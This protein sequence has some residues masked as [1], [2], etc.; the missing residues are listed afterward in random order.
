MKIILI[1]LLV[2]CLSSF[3]ACTHDHQKSF[4]IWDFNKT[5]QPYLIKVVSNGI[6]GYDTA[7]RY[8]EKHATDNELKALSQSEHPVLRALAFREMLER[9]TFN[10][11]DLMMNNLDDTA[12]VIVD[13]GE[14][15]YQFMRVSDDILQNG[16]W[17]DTIMKNKTVDAVITKHNYLKSAYM[18]VSNIKTDNK[19]YPYIKDMATR[20]RNYDEDVG[21]M[22][23]DE[24]ENALYALAAFKKPQDIPVIKEL[25][26]RNYWRMSY[27]SFGLMQEFPNET[28]LDVFEK[29]YHYSF[30]RT[31]CRDQH[32][33]IAI[34]FIHSIAI[35][36]NERSEKILSSIL[37]RKPFMPCGADTNYLKRELIFAIWNNPCEA[38]LKIRKQVENS[39]KH[40]E[41]NDKKNQIELPPLEVDTTLFRKDTSKEKEL[42]RWWQ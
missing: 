22:A 26:M 11:F 13:E 9:P 38:Y 17:K 18:V 23:F 12:M 42:I 33:D 1:I 10:H 16:R 21:E 27:S 4:A 37:N 19:Y 24:I 6:V 40:Y 14:F 7:T 32:I 30:Y 31:I 25:L 8:I 15:G 3:S 29:F 5:L 34:S 36:K 20:K 2:A 41:E 39:V 28:Y 35:Y